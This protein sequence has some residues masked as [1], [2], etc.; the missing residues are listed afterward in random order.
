M[1]NFFKRKNGIT[2][3]ALIV[4]I[5][6]MLILVGVVVNSAI[7]EGG[8][9]KT[10]KELETN[11]ELATIE[12][13]ERINT[14]KA[15]REATIHGIGVVEGEDSS[16][17]VIN[18]IIVK[19]KTSNSITVQV[20]GKETAS[21]IKKIEY[22]KDNG[23]TYVTDVTNLV[24]TSYTFERLLDYTE[25]NIKVKI[26]DN[27]DNFSEATIN[28]VTTSNLIPAQSN[29]MLNKAENTK[30]K[31]Q[32][33]IV[34]IPAGYKI[35]NNTGYT[36]D[37]GIVITDNSTNGNEWVWVPVELNELGTL[38]NVL[39]TKSNVLG[40]THL[41]GTTGVTT[42]KYSKSE[43]ISSQ[44]RSYPGDTSA[45]REPDIVTSYDNDER[46]QKAGFTN[47]L[48]MAQTMVTEY[49]QML[50]S[51]EEYGGFYIGRFELSGTVES[52]KVQRGTSDTDMPLANTDWYD[53]Y[54]ACKKLSANENVVKSR[55]VWGCLW[56]ETCKFIAKGNIYDVTNSGSWGNY[57]SS[58]GN[59]AVVVDGQNKYGTK[60][61]PG[62]SEYWKAK[63]IYD[64]AGN[65]KEWTQEAYSIQSRTARGGACDNYAHSHPATYRNSDSANSAGN[66]RCGTRPVLIL[67]P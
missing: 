40:G 51:I 10:A 9:L 19:S 3:I 48:D 58:N 38:E 2:I 36:I 16:D 29:S 31:V 20:S 26:T 24:A 49:N 30:V 12:G 35:A 60:Q 27:N 59:A 14:L 57:V 25:Y 65:V 15:E 32:N 33:N 64:F 53:L 21:G 13:Q 43:I 11:E 7:G 8:F 46:A 54:K 44:T 6:I 34:W 18:S 63:N 42:D 37:E 56:D 4:T 5:V 17:P 41:S 1:K 22:S 52:P 45:Y 23:E 28:V 61:M 62:Y 47:L 66:A 55:M 50:A 67:I 39:Y